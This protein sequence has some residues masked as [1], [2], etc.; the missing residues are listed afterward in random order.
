MSKILHEQNSV[1]GLKKSKT[2]H[3]NER[4]YVTRLF[5]E[6]RELSRVKTFQKGSNEK[7]FQAACSLW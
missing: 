4:T 3:T 1:S 2:R 7:G 5:L 6:E